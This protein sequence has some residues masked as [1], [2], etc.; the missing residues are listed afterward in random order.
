MSSSSRIIEIFYLLN[1]ISILNVGSLNISPIYTLVLFSFFIFSYDELVGAFFLG[2]GL[3]ISPGYF[4]NYIFLF[5]FI[6]G[7]KYRNVNAK[8]YILCLICSLSLFYAISLGL[9]NDFNVF[10]HIYNYF[11]IADTSPNLNVLWYLQNQVI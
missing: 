9:S 3:M 10:K 4:F 11:T 5:A 1:P 2:F 7:N 6:L 8:Y